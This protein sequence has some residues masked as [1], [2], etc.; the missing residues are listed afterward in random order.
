MTTTTTTT[1]PT[2][3]ASSWWSRVGGII[4]SPRQGFTALIDDDRAHLVE[5]LLI[6][7]V[8]VFS[9]AG[10]E[11]YRLLAL[12]SVA[13]LIVMSRLLDVLLR[14][15]RTDFAVVIGAAV[16]VGGIARGLGQRGI[17]AAVATTYLL[18]LLALVKAAGGLLALLGFELWLLPHR[19]VDSFAVIVNARVDY[20]RVIVKIVAAY[21]PGLVVLLLWLK[22]QLRHAEA[23]V[24][25]ERRTRFGFGVI[26]VVVGTLL[27]SST[28]KVLA[29]REQLRPRLFGDAFPSV[30]LKKLTGRGRVDIAARAATAGTRVVVVD[31][32]ASWCGPCRRS[33][34]ELSRLAQDFQGKGVVVVGVNREPDDLPA[35]QKTWAEIAPAF[36]SLVD[37]KGLGERIGLT[38][39]PSSFVL[40]SHGVIRH[41]H[42]GYTNPAVLSAEVEALLLETP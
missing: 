23:K 12:A 39:L 14:A 27:L 9:I 33:L 1:A 40:D 24:S 2:T 41:L 20:S 22:A 30:P 5:P 25:D 11:V 28:G 13:P 3:R 26:V 36:L 8:V 37:D 17:G 4:A 42:L 29:H 21:L 19:A 16:V 35:A 15:G 31:F 38:S 32:W 18:V 6:Y 7:A 10:A 34:P